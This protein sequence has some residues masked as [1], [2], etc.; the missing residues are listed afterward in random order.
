MKHTLSALK[1]KIWEFFAINR[2]LVTI[3]KA[4]RLRETR[5]IFPYTQVTGVKCLQQI[6]EFSFFLNNEYFKETNDP[7]P[8]LIHAQS[9]EVS[10]RNV[11]KMC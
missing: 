3:S 7:I 5:N 2:L 11:L 4:Q 10:T 8:V 9:P 1:F 6:H